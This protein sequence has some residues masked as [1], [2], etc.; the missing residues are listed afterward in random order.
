MCGIIAVS[1]QDTGRCDAFV[2]YTSHAGHR[3]GGGRR[4]DSV[5]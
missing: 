4:K 2:Q 5:S 1:F 3:K